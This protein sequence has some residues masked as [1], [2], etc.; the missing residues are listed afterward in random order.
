MYHEKDLL[1]ADSVWH[2]RTRKA[3]LPENITTDEHVA[4]LVVNYLRHRHTNYDMMIAEASTDDDKLDIRRLVLDSIASAY[5]WLR[6]ACEQQHER[7]HRTSGY[8]D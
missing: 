6:M 3:C 8:S 7:W 2:F 1:I 5:Y 4:G